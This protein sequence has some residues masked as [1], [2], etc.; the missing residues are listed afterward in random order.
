MSVVRATQNIVL[1]DGGRCM[2]AAYNNYSG[3]CALHIDSN[4]RI[5]RVVYIL[6]GH[7]FSLECS[8]RICRFI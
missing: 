3:A 4:S 1:V 7:T 5:C 8:R 2:G 6:G